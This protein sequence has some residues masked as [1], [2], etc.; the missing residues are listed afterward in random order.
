MA[1]GVSGRE[2]SDRGDLPF[3]RGGQPWAASHRF[4]RGG[5]SCRECE[6]SGGA[7]EEAGEIAGV[8]DWG[9]PAGAA[10]GEKGCSGCGER[11][12]CNHVIILM[13]F[14]EHLDF[15]SPDLA[16]FLADEGRVL[17]ANIGCV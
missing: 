7:A 9:A 5:A 17:L 12:D 16:G 14:I 3:Q 13:Q 4:K 15:I 6:R 10:E 2:H 1:R 11:V 8:A